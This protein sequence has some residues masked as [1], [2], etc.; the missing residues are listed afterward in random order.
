MKKR[1]DA[2][3][4]ILDEFDSGECCEKRTGT[5]SVSSHFQIDYSITH[6][7]GE[8]EPHYCQELFLGYKIASLIDSFNF[9]YSS[10]VFKDAGIDEDFYREII[11]NKTKEPGYNPWFYGVSKE[12]IEEM[13]RLAETLNK[14]IKK[15]LNPFLVN[16]YLDEQSFI[17]LMNLALMQSQYAHESELPSFIASSGGVNDGRHRTC[18]ALKTGTSYIYVN[19][20]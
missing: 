4:I 15:L 19:E 20:Y 13:D 16:N 14:D 7:S 9:Q 17:R 12:S 6:A 18:I 2:N 10:D 8:S 3:I 11:L 5:C 1:I